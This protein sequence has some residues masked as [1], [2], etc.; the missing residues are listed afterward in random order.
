M[1]TE[2]QLHDNDT[3]TLTGPQRRAL[4]D[5]L[6]GPFVSYAKS[7]EIFTTIAHSRTVLA[8]QLDNLFL[9][10]IVDEQAGIAYAKSWDEEVA[11][12][13]ALFRT[14][15][16]TFMDTVLLLHLRRELIMTNPND[17]AIVDEDEVYEAT[18]P[19]HAL[20]GTDHTAARKKFDAAWNKMKTNSI[21][22][23]T[24]TEG[25][26]EVSP[27]LRII[28]SADEVAAVSASYDTLQEETNE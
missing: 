8:E 7:P 13:R 23:S 21:V 1:T 16:L 19:Y 24:P 27:V 6:R 9:Q 25:R 11:E 4:T 28:F 22:N 17:R 3:G 10:L 26:F 20:A 18:L 5:L 15:S 14:V 12:K 2:H